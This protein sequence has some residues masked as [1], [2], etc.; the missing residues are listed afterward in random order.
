MA[1]VKK[2]GGNEPD[3]KADKQCQGNEDDLRHAHLPEKQPHGDYLCVLNEDDY[4]GGDNNC[5]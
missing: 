4:N 5:R 3:D 2:G 1:L